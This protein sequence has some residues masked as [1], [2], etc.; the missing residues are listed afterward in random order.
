MIPKKLKAALALAAAV[1]LTA[2]PAQVVAPAAVAVPTVIGAPVVTAVP[3]QVIAPPSIAV[4]A[5]LAPPSLSVPGGTTISPPSIA[6]G[7][8][9]S[10]GGEKISRRRADMAKP[11]SFAGSWASIRSSF[12]FRDRYVLAWT[13]CSTRGVG[14]GFRP[15]RYRRSSLSIVRAGRWVAWA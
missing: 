13:S 12:A 3:A 11:R 10:A 4:P 5:V 7:A 8:A 6:G 15:A 14:A 1:A 9:G 2:V